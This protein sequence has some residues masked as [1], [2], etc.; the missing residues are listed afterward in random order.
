LRVVQ[1]L[2]GHA[3]IRTTMRYAHLAPGLCRD[4]VSVLD[5]DRGGHYLGTES[6]EIEKKTHA[7]SLPGGEN[8]LEFVGLSTGAR[9]E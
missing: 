9:K 5:D 4:A 6:S 3:D 7:R 1:E 8:E 2:L